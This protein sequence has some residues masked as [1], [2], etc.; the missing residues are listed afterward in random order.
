MAMTILVAT[1]GSN[2]A[3][4]GARLA[5]ELAQATGD[6]LLFVTVWQELRGDF[7]VPL[8]KIAP[9][10]VE[11]EREHA[12]QVLAEAKRQAEAAGLPAET[13]SRHG[14]AAHEIC[15]VAR[16][17]DA[18]MI[19]IGSHGQG[20]IERALFGSVAHAVAHTA[21]CPVLLVPGRESPPGA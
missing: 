15:L 20:A 7:G 6:D 4:A 12:A 10:L 9:D 13:I 17:H 2:A 21:P 3:Q 5:Q 14:D 8:G 18:R 16:E 1:D 19:V 11:V